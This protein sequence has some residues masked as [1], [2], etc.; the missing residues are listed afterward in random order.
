MQVD[1]FFIGIHVQKQLGGVP[2]PCHSVK[3]MPSPDQG[4][5]GNRIQF[6]QV[7]TGHPEK[8]A[9]HQVGIPDGLQFG[10][11]IKDIKCVPPLPGDLLVDGHGKSLEAFVRI[12][13]PNLDAGQIL[14]NR[15][16]LGETDVDHIPPIRHRLPGKGLREHTE[17]L[18]LRNLPH[19]IISKADAIQNGVHLGKSAAY[20]VKRCHKCP[21]SPKIKGRTAK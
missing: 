21:P 9:H 11:A 2:D 20:L 16:V 19:H 7:G 14:Q 6:K 1:V 4:E 17:L 3:G 12:K 13:L 15:L 5:I 10:Q 8:V 18:Q